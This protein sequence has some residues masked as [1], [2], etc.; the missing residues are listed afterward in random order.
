MKFIATATGLM[1]LVAGLCSCAGPT[2]NSKPAESRALISQMENSIAN[3]LFDDA[4]N[5]LLDRSPQQ[6]SYLG[7]RDKYDQWDD[8]SDD[9]ARE[10]QQIVERQ[11]RE[12]QRS[13]DYERLDED[14]K[15]SY[16]LFEYNTRLRQQA[17]RYRFH[18]YPVDQMNGMQSAVPA[19]LINIHPSQSDED[20]EAYVTRLT[21]VEALFEQLIVNL[22]MRAEKGVVIPLFVFHH[23]I[24]DSQNII[25]GKPFSDSNEDSTLL[26][27]FKEKVNR[28]E[29]NA[30]SKSELIDK[31]EV[32]LLESVQPAYEKLIEYLAELERQAG[33][34][35]G[36]W[37]FPDGEAFYSQALQHT[38]TTELNPSQVHQIGVDEVQRI[39]REMRTILKLLEFDGDL[40]DFF[41][42][43][44][45]DSQFYFSN[46]PAGKQSY[47]S[48]AVDIIATMQERLDDLF[49]RQPNADLIIKAVEPFREKSAGKAFYNRP[50]ADGSRPGIFYAN[51]Y[52][53]RDM[54]KYELEALAHHEGIPGHHMQISVATEL[55]GIP[56]FR[57]FGRFTAYTEGWALYME[58]VPKELGFY[59]DPYA[60]FGRLALELWRACRLVV[61]TGI[62]WQRWTRE[63][64]IQ[65]LDDNTPSPHNQNVKA[66][67]RYIVMPS[68]ATAYKIG[69]LK[70]LA[71]RERSMEQLGDRF[72]IR[73]Y[74]D[75]VLRSGP[76]PLTMLEEVVDR[77]LASKR[78]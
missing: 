62:H 65:Y 50:A 59:A 76:L 47:L 31:A 72:D 30:N 7:F 67:E 57:K 3:K 26:A 55:T 36:A 58:Y 46:T 77:W 21:G 28:L 9:Y 24:S 70:F 29:I 4:F 33:S 35:D 1:L 32:A 73:E 13:V 66:I 53:T 22:K 38:T 12:I 60:D 23:V 8:I 14:T 5:E 69:M 68:Q 52:D 54:P 42:Y 39:H 71:L 43:V 6:Q 64:A 40:Q 51:L 17:F 48:M 74:H 63:Q 78:L 75:V 27:D 49:L 56:K 20:M 61:D 2:P 34:D 18:N 19:F 11:W 15:L 41:H 44:R 16:Q 45:T 37:K 10:T 25:S